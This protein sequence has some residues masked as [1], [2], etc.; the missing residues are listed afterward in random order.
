MKTIQLKM[1]LI[2]FL[3]ASLVL[4]TG[5]LSIYTYLNISSYNKNKAEALLKNPKDLDDIY[6]KN[7][8]NQI[9]YK[10][11]KLIIFSS[12]MFL[13]FISGLLYLKNHMTGK[14][15]DPLMDIQIKMLDFLNGQY[16]YK[17][18]TPTEDEMGRL[19]TTFNSMAQEVLTNMNELKALDEAKSDFLNIASHE[20]RTPM[21]S[22]KGS[23]GLITAGALGNLSEDVM[24]LMKIAESETDRLIRLTN[25][26]LDMAKI[27]ARKMPLN[28]S[29]FDL[30][31]LLEK[32]VDGLVGFSTAAQ[33]EIKIHDFKSIVAF[34]DQDRIQQVITNLLSNAI[35]FSPPKKSIEII[36]KAEPDKHLVINVQ[37]H[38]KGMSP[39]Q[40]S[41]LFQK[42]RQATSPDNP[43]VKG[44]GL[45]LA[46]AK[47][48]VEEHHGII[49]VES[50]PNEGSTFFFSLPEWKF[51]SDI[52][53]KAS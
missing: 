40:K 30:R 17:F 42:F 5:G 14:I 23:L 13:F 22:I 45:G 47:A 49:G 6:I 38:G 32:T 41:V 1:S 15:F 52:E 33:V 4:A 16:S 50:K 36:V 34:G 51:A 39:Q 48:L 53:M 19:Q 26:I 18:E 43:L 7:W 8:D 29:W 35:K 37:D 2:I 9:K 20:L 21:T 31:Q 44:T 27:E 3:T 28:L 25:D 12:L 24:G 11:K 10:E 46:I